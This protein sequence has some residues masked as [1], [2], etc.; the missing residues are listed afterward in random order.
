VPLARRRHA[1]RD[2]FNPLFRQVAH[3]L[4]GVTGR[5]AMHANHNLGLFVRP[6]VCSGDMFESESR[7]VMNHRPRPDEI[8]LSLRAE[9]AQ[10]FDM[11]PWCVNSNTLSNQIIAVKNLPLFIGFR[12]AIPAFGHT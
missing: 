3:P 12:H 6:A 5:P 9:V 7:H 4:A 1:D 11:V 2:G 10:V 8:Y